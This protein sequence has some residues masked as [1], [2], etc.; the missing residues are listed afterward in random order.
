MIL[1]NLD[2]SFLADKFLISVGFKEKCSLL[3][4]LTKKIKSL[5]SDLLI[6]NLYSDKEVEYIKNNKQ[7]IWNFEVEIALRTLFI[8]SDNNYPNLG[9]TNGKKVIPEKCFIEIVKVNIPRTEFLEN[10]VSSGKSIFD[11]P[12]NKEDSFI[13]R[14]IQNLYIKFL[15]LSWEV[16]EIRYEYFQGWSGRRIPFSDYFGYSG[17][18]FNGYYS[19]TFLK[20]NGINTTDQLKKKFPDLYTELIKYKSGDRELSNPG[21]N[22]DVILNRLK[23]LTMFL[24]R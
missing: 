2:R 16:R 22:K 4:E 24:D 19:E 5:S 11:F 10:L 1:T 15:D 20:I 13:F 23:K 7:F 17:N 6:R 12:M 8:S 21:E 14:E 9:F 3:G 18:Y